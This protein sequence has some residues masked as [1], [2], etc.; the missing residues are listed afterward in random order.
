MVIPVCMVEVQGL[1]VIK[2]KDTLKSVAA[3]VTT[4]PRPLHATTHCI[5]Q[6]QSDR[7]SASLDI[8]NLEYVLLH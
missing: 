4:V 2:K 5:V 6:Q 3:M 7:F 8:C 1:I